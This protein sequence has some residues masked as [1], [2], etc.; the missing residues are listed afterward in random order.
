MQRICFECEGA[1]VPIFIFYTLITKDLISN[2][3]QEY[4]GQNADLFL[5][6]LSVSPAGK[7]A[8]YIDKFQGMIDIEQC[9]LLSKFIE[10]NLDRELQDFELQVSS[11]GM[12]SPFKVKEQ[13]IKNL[14]KSVKILTYDGKKHEG[15]L[16]EVG[17]DKLVIEYQVK[18][19]IEGKK[20]KELVTKVESYFFNS[21]TN[22][23]KIKE[24]KKVISF[25]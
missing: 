18:E 24:T 6:D 23:N 2:I 14:N 4:L 5:V 9:V 1:R 3:I 15:V 22:N 10:S 21:D 11:A 12:T 19:K 13:Y 20:K 8:V 25:N 16:K 7:I 17:D